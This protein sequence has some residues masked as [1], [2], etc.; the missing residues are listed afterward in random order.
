MDEQLEEHVENAPQGPPPLVPL[1]SSNARGTLSTIGAT[2]GAIGV[3]S[4][5][6]EL[7]MA[8]MVGAPPGTLA[9]LPIPFISAPLGAGALIIG[10]MQLASAPRFAPIPLACAA[11]YFSLFLYNL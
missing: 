4:L 6:L 11:L 5:L 10:L 3:V 8:R 7:L 9:S 2:C 1:F